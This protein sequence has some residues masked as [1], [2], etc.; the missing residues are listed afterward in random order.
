MSLHDAIRDE[1]AKR[2]D[3]TPESSCCVGSIDVETSNSVCE[4]E[5]ISTWK[6]G[7]GQVIAYAEATGKKPILCIFDDIIP[8]NVDI[9]K[10]IC[11]SSGVKFVAMFGYGEILSAISKNDTTKTDEARKSIPKIWIDDILVKSRGSYRDHAILSLIAETDISLRELSRLNIQ[12]VFNGKEVVSKI[13]IN[14]N[15]AIKRNITD[16]QYLIH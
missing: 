11:S 5:P 16:Y 1:L 12:D 15:I 13:F 10:K 4:V 9:V 7:L 2:W 6:H 14:E 8:K 3:G